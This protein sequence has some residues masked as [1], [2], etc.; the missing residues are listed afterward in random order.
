MSNSCTGAL[1]SAHLA[2]E[3]MDLDEDRTVAAIGIALSQASGVME[4]LTNG[5]SVKSLHPG[6]AAHG[7]VIAATLA[8]AGMTGP[9]TSLDGK[10]GLFRQFTGDESAAGR[11]RALI[12]D[13]GR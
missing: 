13:L 11:F 1:A 10:H 8:R 5:S 7:G 12:G 3:L 9:E 4:F 2:A 6:W